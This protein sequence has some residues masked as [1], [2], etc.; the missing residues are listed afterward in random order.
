MPATRSCCSSARSV[1]VARSPSPGRP[2]RHGSSRAASWKTRSGGSQPPASRCG[3]DADDLEGLE[4]D[5]VVLATGAR[6]YENDRLVLD[7]VEVLQAW[8]VL[9]GRLPKAERVVVADWGGDP[10]G[11]DAAEVLVAT[12]QG[13]D[14][15]R[16]VGR[17][18]RARPPVPAQSLPPA[19]LQSGCA[20]L[21]PPRARIDEQRCR[22]P[23]QHLR[24]ASS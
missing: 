22:P 14:A 6:P 21:A 1:S 12:R 23:T 19:A 20:D 7:G 15:R 11:L 4:P 13:G 9:G 5:A 3:S 10:S 16:C 2:R 24:A 8:D 17:G 18:R